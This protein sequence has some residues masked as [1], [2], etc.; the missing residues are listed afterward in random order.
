M[1]N[2]EQSA[3]LHEDNKPVVGLMMREKVLL[4]LGT[5]TITLGGVLMVLVGMN[6]LRRTHRGRISLG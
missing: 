1:G 4:G 5:M 6:H 2:T 3:A